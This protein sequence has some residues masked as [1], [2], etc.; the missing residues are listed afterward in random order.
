M[1]YDGSATTAIA[2]SAANSTP[3]AVIDPSASA[4]F[5]ASCMDFL[6]IELVPMAFRMA[7]ELAAREEEYLAAVPSQIRSTSNGKGGMA[8]PGLVSSNGDAGGKVSVGGPATVA[9][10]DEEELREA[11]LYRLDM[12]GYRVGLGICE[13]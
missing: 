4:Y 7:E 13:R 12:L 3:P 6:L 5:N 10:A 1:S 2:T 9:S 8:S 11:A